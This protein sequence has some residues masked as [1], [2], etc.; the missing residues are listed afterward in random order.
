MIKRSI[1]EGDITIINIFA[2]KIGELQYL[3]Q[4]LTT[5]KGEID[6]DT[7]IVGDFNTL[8]W[9]MDRSS[10]QKISKEAQAL[11]D[12]LGKSETQKLIY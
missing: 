7:I 5:I 6:S 12:I 3:R 8:L 1:Q 2:P 10:R 4:M 9:V 11:N